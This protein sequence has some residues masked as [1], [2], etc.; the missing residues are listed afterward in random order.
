M[1]LFKKVKGIAGSNIRTAV[2]SLKDGANIKN[3]II[4]KV[5]SVDYDKVLSHL[6][7][8]KLIRSK[9]EVLI[10]SVQTLK[11]GAEEYKVSESL[12]KDDDFLNYILSNIDAEKAIAE[13]EPIINLIPMGSIILVILKLLMNYK[14]NL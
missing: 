4:S 3:S 10:I 11:N 14:K 2:D 6:E 13:L 1:G 12:T 9:K 8:D 5:I 7:E